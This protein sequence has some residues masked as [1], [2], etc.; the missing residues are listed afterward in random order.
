MDFWISGLLEDTVRSVID[1]TGRFL[2]IF[3]E[4]EIRARTRAVASN[5]NLKVPADAVFGR[6]GQNALAIF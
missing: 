3:C 1:R 4:R 2:L 6:N 5:I